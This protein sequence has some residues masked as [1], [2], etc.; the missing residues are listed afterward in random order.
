M[1]PPRKTYQVETDRF[2]RL[3]IHF[4]NAEVQKKYDALF[5]LS[6]PKSKPYIRLNDWDV[7]SRLS[8]VND[9]GKVVRP[10]LDVHPT[11]D[12]QPS[13]MDQ[14]TIAFLMERLLE[15]EI[16]AD[17]PLMIS[18]KSGF[19]K[20]MQI[21]FRGEKNTVV[22]AVTEGMPQNTQ[23]PARPSAWQRFWNTMSGGR[24]YKPEIETYNTAKAEFD[25][26]QEVAAR[27]T[28]A[29]DADL[30]KDVNQYSLMDREPTARD[31]ALGVVAD[32]DAFVAKARQN[33]MAVYGL[34][35][36]PAQLVPAGLQKLRN[37]ANL[38]AGSTMH[39]P[40]DISETDYAVICHLSILSE[41]NARKMS[42]D[43][44]SDISH[45]PA[46]MLVHSTEDVN[47]QRE[48]LDIIG[49]EALAGA[50][51]TARNAI[52]QDFEGN[53]IP[54][55]QLVAENLP[56][57]VHNVLRNND[58]VTSKLVSAA[59]ECKQLSSFLD[60]HPKTVELAKRLGL[61]QQ[62]LDALKAC[63]NIV[64]IH[65]RAAQARMEL[66][67]SVQQNP[68]GARDHM[69]D[70]VTEI[71][72]GAVLHQHHDDITSQTEERQKQL[73]AHINTKV[74]GETDA[75]KHARDQVDMIAVAELGVHP[76]ALTPSSDRGIGLLQNPDALRQMISN[77]P[78]MQNF[79]EQVARGKSYADLAADLVNQM[80]SPYHIFDDML[81]KVPLQVPEN[82]KPAAQID[83]A[84]RGPSQEQVLRVANE[85][86]M[87]RANQP[88]AA[89]QMAP[90]P[91]AAPQRHISEVK[92]AQPEQ[93][94]VENQH[95]LEKS[96]AAMT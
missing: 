67:S 17:H 11:G 29:F 23:A 86:L 83:P 55:A 37:A 30:P 79:D 76:L 80:K 35:A 13:R 66:M 33:R 72:A 32:N 36:R 38:E 9:R 74:E 27:Y 87:A 45:A 22:A 41:P 62:E 52:T 3:H 81:E 53:H 6:S 50:H 46:S 34:N 25:R 82:Q 85:E 21:T 84:P 70:I 60:R 92:L 49:G 10:F 26:K 48:G 93:P 91:M 16:D 24:W 75:Q 71:Y 59:D 4:D 14:Q 5:A 63:S 58:G 61:P 65:E 44:M 18:D 1:A 68:I 43:Q 40:N 12:A 95:K 89:P 2:Q 96:G 47:G 94:A 56:M 7:L 28:A 90:D 88:E 54:L 57:L 77:S 51:S 73:I 8:Y 78:I 42:A 31:K 20:P 19:I 64:D 39:L 15:K 69:V